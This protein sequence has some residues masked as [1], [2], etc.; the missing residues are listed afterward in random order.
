MPPGAGS[1]NATFPLARGLDCMEGLGRK[2]KLKSLDKVL[3]VPICVGQDVYHLVKDEHL[4]HL[5]KS[6][7]QTV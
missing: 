1:E 7:A 4:G 6:I 5:R 2:G 3:V